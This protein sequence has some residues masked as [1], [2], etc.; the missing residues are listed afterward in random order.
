VTATDPHGGMRQIVVPPY[1]WPAFERLCAKAQSVLVLLPS[2]RQ[3]DLPTYVI[4]PRAAGD[5]K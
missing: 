3:D 2:E 5:S 1:A 4:H